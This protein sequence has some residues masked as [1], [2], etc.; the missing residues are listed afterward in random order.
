MSDFDELLDQV[1]KEDARV[2]P[3]LGFEQRILA[4]LRVEASRKGWRRIWWVPAGVFA[5]LAVAVALMVQH[6]GSVSHS[7]AKQGVN[8]GVPQ[9]GRA[10]LPTPEKVRKVFETETLGSDHHSGPPLLPRAGAGRR[11]GPQMTQSEEVG[12]SRLPKMETFPAV[13]QSGGFLTEPVTS[14]EVKALREAADSPLVAQALQ[15]LKAEQER[16]LE[17]SAIEIEPL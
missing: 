12:E 11:A 14:G 1:L 6:W 16:P 7:A 9:A 13:A 3:R 2:E 5:G 17:V 8:L 15:E 10:S 4:G